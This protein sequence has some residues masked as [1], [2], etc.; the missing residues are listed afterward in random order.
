MA[1]PPPPRRSLVFYR[2]GVEF[3]IRPGAPLLFGGIAAALD[4]TFLPSAL[5]DQPTLAYHLAA[6]AIT[7]LMIVTT[8]LH[9]SGHALAY[10]AQ[11]IWPVRVTLRGSG[12]ACAAMVDEDKPGQAL[13]R[14]LAGPAVTALVATTLFL[15]WRTL[16]LPPLWRLVAA[17]LA[18]FSAF[19]L[20]FN[21]LPVHPR[22]DGAHAL[23]AA[24]W[25]LRGQEPAPFAVLYVWRPIVLAAAALLCPTA[26]ALTGLLPTGSSVSAIAGALALALCAVPLGALALR[27]LRG[28]GLIPARVRHAAS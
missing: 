28:R 12:G 5:P 1:M 9:E 21:T 10:R 20:V 11:G 26:G 22:C 4:V 15:A 2:G 25:L 17:T 24:V 27:A 18:V 3:V 13:V 6:V 23:R 19:D 14:A 8:L 7:V 16:P